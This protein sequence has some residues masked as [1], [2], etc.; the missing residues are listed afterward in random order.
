MIMLSKEGYRAWVL[1]R[2][3]ELKRDHPSRSKK[4][5]WRIAQKEWHEL[6]RLQKRAERAAASVTSVPRV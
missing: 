4:D 6:C 3:E 5:R 2:M 1:H